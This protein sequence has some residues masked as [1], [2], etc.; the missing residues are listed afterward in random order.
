MHRPQA[1]GYWPM[2]HPNIRPEPVIEA[3]PAKS[4][5][6]KVNQRLPFNEDCI[7]SM[8]KYEM[9]VSRMIREAK[10]SCE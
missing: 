1:P 8:V 4:L 6:T 9:S 3:V 10:Y 5:K 2:M 7:E